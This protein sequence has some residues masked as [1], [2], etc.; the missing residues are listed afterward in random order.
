[1]TQ[2]SLSIFVL[3]VTGYIGGSLLRR[4]AIQYPQAHITALVRNNNVAALFQEAGVHELLLGSHKDLDTIETACSNAELVINV[5][6]CD[7]TELTAA[8]LRGLKKRFEKTGRR[9]VLIHTSGTGVICDRAHGVLNQAVASAPYDDADEQRTA[10]IPDEAYHRL[11]DKMIFQADS[12]G[13]IDGWII[14]PPTIYGT[15]TGPI[16]RPTFQIPVVIPRLAL[17]AKQ[18][19]VIGD[20]SATWDNVHIDDLIDLYELLLVKALDNETRATRSSPYSKFVLVSS[21]KHTWSEATQA[22]ADALHAKGL[23]PTKEIKS[24]SFEEAIALHPTAQWVCTNSFCVP[25]KARSW[26]WKPK[27]LGWRVYLEADLEDGLKS[28]GVL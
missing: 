28:L 3:G 15:S 2:D 4:L 12:D 6:D 27:H 25:R 23:I 19:V 14:A 26:G 20:G 9:P 5:A 1:M 18:P 21:G 11:V 16:R 10:A 13:Y 22:V 7:D 17:A 8:V 24:V